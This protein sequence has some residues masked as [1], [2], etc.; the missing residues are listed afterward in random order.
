METRE[1]IFEAALNSEAA[2]KNRAELV[3]ARLGYYEWEA[4]G[5]IVGDD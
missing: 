5:I 3:K 2:L 4:M 1:N